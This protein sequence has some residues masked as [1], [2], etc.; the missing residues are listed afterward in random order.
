MK[1]YL[2]IKIMNSVT[3]FVT[4]WMELDIIILTIKYRK[5]SAKYSHLDE[6]CKK[7]DHIEVGRRMEYQTLGVTLEQG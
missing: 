5:V 3:A 1:Y 2:V 7:C 6:E 4:I